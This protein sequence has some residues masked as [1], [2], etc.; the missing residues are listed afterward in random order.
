PSTPVLA[1]RHRDYSLIALKD[2][3]YGP[4]PPPRPP[5]PFTL[6]RIA[7]VVLKRDDKPHE[8]TVKVSGVGSEGAKV[9]ASASG[10]LLPEGELKVDPKTHAITIPGVAEDTSDYAHSTVSVVAT[11]ADGKTLK[12]SFK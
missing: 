2:L 4:L 1:T 11:S 9:V 10:N 3:F 8:V 7:D 5:E 12:G 6:G